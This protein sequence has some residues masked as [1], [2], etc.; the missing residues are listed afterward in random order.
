MHLKI[1]LSNVSRRLCIIA[2][3]FAALVAVIQIMTGW[4]LWFAA[5]AFLIGMFVG[6]QVERGQGKPI[7][8][9]GSSS[10]W[11]GRSA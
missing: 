9:A 3:V 5:L 10:N 6:W 11:R 7:T 2:L 1:T 8:G 4:G